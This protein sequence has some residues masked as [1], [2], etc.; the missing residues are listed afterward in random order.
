M[1]RTNKQTDRQT[2]GLELELRLEQ[3]VYSSSETLESDS[4]VNSNALIREFGSFRKLSALRAGSQK[5]PGSSF[6]QQ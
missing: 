4:N 1:L 6:Q 2:D 5:S 3:T